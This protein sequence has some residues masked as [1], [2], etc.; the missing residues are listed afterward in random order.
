VGIPRHGLADLLVRY[1]LPTALEGGPLQWK[2]RENAA[3]I[4]VDPLSAAANL[5][6]FLELAGL[7]AVRE[8][9][10]GQKQAQ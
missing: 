4:N 3:T 8:H 7:G 2:S 6:Q 1:R 10:Q 5:L 9:W